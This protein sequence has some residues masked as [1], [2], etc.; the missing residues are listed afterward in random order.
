MRLAGGHVSIRCAQELRAREV[1]EE[2][3]KEERQAIEEGR[4]GERRAQRA[5]GLPFTPAVRQADRREEAAAEAGNEERQAI[6]EEREAGR[7]A[8]RTQASPFTP[9]A[10]EA[11]RRLEAEEWSDDSSMPDSP[12]SVDLPSIGI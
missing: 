2:A 11:D 3:G 4:E 9:G 12:Y 10:R 8:Q 6:E 7:R 1:V 5:P